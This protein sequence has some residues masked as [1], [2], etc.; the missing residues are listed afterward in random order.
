V[1]ESDGPAS[2]D[3]SGKFSKSIVSR[4]HAGY[5]GRCSAIA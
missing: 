3:M 1:R 5:I 4:A 2:G